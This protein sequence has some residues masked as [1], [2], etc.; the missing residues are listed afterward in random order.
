[1]ETQNTASKTEEFINGV[2]SSA[3]IED[4]DKA[5]VKATGDPNFMDKFADFVS[6]NRGENDYVTK[7]VRNYL[8][9]K[10]AINGNT[11]Q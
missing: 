2:Y 7:A 11:I 6:E 5:A 8:A 1:M 3:T 4:M 9:H 10:H